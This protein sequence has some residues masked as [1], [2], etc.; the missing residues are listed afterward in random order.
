MKKR[1]PQSDRV[2]WSP[3]RARYQRFEFASSV[4]V[5]FPNETKRP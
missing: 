3:N 4:S 2:Q 5:A 1:E